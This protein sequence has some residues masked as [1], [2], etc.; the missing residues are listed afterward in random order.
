MYSALSA[1]RLEVVMEG[2]CYNCGYKGRFDWFWLIVDS[3]NDS[4]A[5]ATHCMS[6]E[7][8]KIGDTHLEIYYCPNCKAEQ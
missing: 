4:T 3:K 2:A 6:N 8:S 1:W 7:E 5:H